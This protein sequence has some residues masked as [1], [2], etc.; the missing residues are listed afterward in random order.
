MRILITGAGGFIGDHLA[1][2]LQK[3]DEV[4]GVD[5]KQPEFGPTNCD[6]FVEAD[7][8][9]PRATSRLLNEVWP[10]VVFMLAADMGGMGYIKGHDAT[11][12]HNNL[13]INV[14]TLAAAREV[15]VKRALFSS[16]ACV[17]PLGLQDVEYAR[18]LAEDDAYP[19]DPED[20]Y[21]WEKLTTEKLCQYY[22][23][24][25]GLD[26]RVARFHNIY[27]PYGTWRGGREK[28]PA[29]LCRKVAEAKL[30]GAREIEV[31]GD[32]EQTRT[33]C[34][35][36]DCIEGLVRLMGSNYN[37]PINL[38]R[39][40]VVSINELAYRIMAIAGYT[41]D[42]KHVA[43]PQGVRGRSSDNTAMRRVLDW[44]PVITLNDG[45]FD[46]Y[47]WIESQVKEHSR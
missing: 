30:F 41:C 18:N 4:V 47:H 6:T 36:D 1:K 31:W 12:M 40:E 24:E 16:S 9:D 5:I 7:L 33:Y 28:S 15:G 45:L 35:V 21:G 37:P 20:G 17:Y 11:I 22:T 26:T 10:E 19:A 25:Y 34:H 13:L 43:G 8:R 39:D 44:E 27:G 42:I 29:A 23:T 46:T 2:R 14:N 32:G 3:N 38:G